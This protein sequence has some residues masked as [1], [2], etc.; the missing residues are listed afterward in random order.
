MLGPAKPGAIQA[1]LNSSSTEA[2]RD[3]DEEDE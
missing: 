3:A 1:Y 2:Q